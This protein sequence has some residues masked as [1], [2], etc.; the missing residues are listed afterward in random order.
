[1]PAAGGEDAAAAYVEVFAEGWRAPADADSLADHFEPWLD[2]EFRFN[3]PVL[4]ATF[5]GRS[6]FRRH[7]ARATLALL[8]DIHGTVERWASAGDALFIELRVEATVGSR[9]V[10]F[11]VCDRYLLRD[12][13]PVE[14]VTYA[15]PTPVIVALLRAPRLWPRCVAVAVRAVRAARGTA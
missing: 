11:G 4:G 5:V 15:D 7:F 14:R 9:P 10:S 3:L 1:M 13:R 8:D 12:G 2:P 6:A